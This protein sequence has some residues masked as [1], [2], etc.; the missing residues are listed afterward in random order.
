[1]KEHLIKNLVV[2]LKI[3]AV[4]NSVEKLSVT[5]FTG[6]SHVIE[7]PHS[8]AVHS[9][10]ADV[11]ELRCIG[12]K[13]IINHTPELSPPLNTEIDNPEKVSIIKAP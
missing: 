12:L 5:D 6:K 4:D 2:F 8:P 7:I 11:L 13:G 3:T 1:M 9:F 10:I